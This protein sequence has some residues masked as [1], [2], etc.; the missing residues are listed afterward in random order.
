MPMQLEN[1]TAKTNEEM[2]AGKICRAKLIVGHDL[3]LRAERSQSLWRPDQH[4]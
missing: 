4:T 2:L 3:N 1:Y